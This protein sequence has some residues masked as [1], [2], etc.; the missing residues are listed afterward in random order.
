MKKYLIGFLLMLP[1]IFYTLSLIHFCFKN[2]GIILKAIIYF[3]MGIICYILFM[4]GIDY[5]EFG[6]E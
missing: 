4:I 3:L 5:I 6:E 1:S 2:F